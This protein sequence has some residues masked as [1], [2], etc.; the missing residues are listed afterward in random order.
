MFLFFL[1]FLIFGTAW[2]MP[3][4]AALECE[5]L[6]GKYLLPQEECLFSFG[7]G[8]R[9]P[10]WD[11]VT[12]NSCAGHQ[13]CEEENDCPEGEFCRRPG[14]FAKGICMPRPLYCIELYAP[15]CGCDGKTYSNSCFAEANGVTVAYPGECLPGGIEL[16][17]EVQENQVSLAWKASQPIL[18][19]VLFY[20]PYPQMRPIESLEMG[21]KTSF[22]VL[23]P[24]GSAYYVAIGGYDREGVLHLSPINY[25]RLPP[26]WISP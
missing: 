10:A 1:V 6:G 5:N 13:V 8:F 18:R 2:A 17:L 11:L 9:C 24:A 20:A 4:P 21:Q 25:F 22:S 23:L 16:E 3:N 15:V 12:Q 19:Y 7:E 26:R 14:C